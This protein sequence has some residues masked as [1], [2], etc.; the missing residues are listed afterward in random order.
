M[1]RLK[2]PSALIYMEAMGPM[3]TMT[4]PVTMF[5]P[6]LELLGSLTSKSQEGDEFQR[7]IGKVKYFSLN[8]QVWV[9]TAWHPGIQAMT[10]ITTGSA[11]P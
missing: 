5:L 4:I 10:I 3:Q 7:D 11:P 6:L 9:V 1:A 8:S 2:I